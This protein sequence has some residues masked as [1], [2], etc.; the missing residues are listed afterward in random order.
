M[1]LAARDAWVILLVL[2]ECA[3]ASDI[4]GTV[5]TKAARD[6][7]DAVVYIDQIPGKFFPAPAEHAIMDQVKLT[8]TPHILP[9]LAGTTVDFLNSDNDLHNIYSPTDCADRFN[10]GS[11]LKGMKRSR[12]FDKPGC[13][14]VI[15]CN[16]HLAMSAYVVVLQTPFWCVIGKDGAFQIK[17]VP[18]GSYTLKIWHPKLKGNAQQVKVGAGDV[19]VNFELTK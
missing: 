8:F 12:L 11:T 5:T 2:T 4:H 17:N 19:A 18:A 7:S 16:I 15:L 10:L 1:T 6:A 14:P 13:T 9:I 3:F